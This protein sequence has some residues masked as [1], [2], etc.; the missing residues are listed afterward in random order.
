MYMSQCFSYVG[1]GLFKYGSP[2]KIFVQQEFIVRIITFI[3]TKHKRRATV[4]RGA[5][6]HIAWCFHNVSMLVIQHRM[7]CNQLDGYRIYINLFEILP[8]AVQFSQK[9]KK[10]KPLRLVF[11]C[12][13]CACIIAKYSSNKLKPTTDSQNAAC[14][15]CWLTDLGLELQQWI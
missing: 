9:K 5:V 12:S 8:E 13:G 11:M 15:E 10:R 14:F 7:S 3:N 2:A 6:C 1:Y 4:R